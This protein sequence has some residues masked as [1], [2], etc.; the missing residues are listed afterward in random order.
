MSEMHAG[1]TRVHNLSAVLGEPLC[2]PAA[3]VSSLWLSYKSS[4]REGVSTEMRGCWHLI[5]ME[6][7]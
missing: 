4:D 2:P 5:Q 6:K 7:K 1:D 3:A